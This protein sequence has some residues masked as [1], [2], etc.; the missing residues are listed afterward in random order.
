MKTRIHFL[1]V[2]ALLAAGAAPLRAATPVIGAQ[3]FQDTGIRIENLFKYRNNPPKPPSS[4]D[5]PF[6]VGDA[7]LASALPV[8]NG[9]PTP[10]GPTPGTSDEAILRQAASAL[11]FGGILQVGDVEVLVINKTGYKEGGIL[12]V[13]LQGSPVYLRIVSITSNSVTLGLNEA[14][15]TLHF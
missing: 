9:V 8:K 1:A 11:V 15:L 3:L 4:V 6:R 5:D 2:L 13:R 7:P 12:M 10:D 14:R